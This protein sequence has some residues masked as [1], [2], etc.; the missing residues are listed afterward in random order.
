VAAFL[1][2]GGAMFR[3]NSFILRLFVVLSLLVAL[4]TG[5]IG[6]SIYHRS[7]SVIRDEVLLLNRGTLR[8]VADGLSLILEDGIKLAERISYDSKL[9]EVL[10][11]PGAESSSVGTKEQMKVVSEKIIADYVWSRSN[12]KTLFDAYVIGYNGLTYSTYYSQKY[13]MQS[14]QGDPIYSEIIQR[15]D[16]ITLIDTRSDPEAGGAFRYSFQVAG[17]ISDLITRKPCGFLILNI[18]EKTLYDGYRNIMSEGKHCYVLGQTGTIISSKDKRNIGGIYSAWDHDEMVLPPQGTVLGE[19][20]QEA[21]LIY[22][23]IPGSQW[24]LV[25]EIPLKNAMAAW[26]QIR[27]FILAI[28]LTVIILM[29]ALM[30]WFARQALTP[31]MMIKDKMEQVTGGDL[32]V[33][34]S[35]HRNDEFGQISDSFNAMVERTNSLILAVK[36]EERQ[37]RIVELDFLRAQI[38]PHFI[39]NTLTSIRSFVEMNKNEEAENMLFHFSKLLR[40]TL[41]RSVEFIS[42][43]DELNTIRDYVELQKLRYTEQ[44]DVEYDV[45]DE[46]LGCVITSFILQPIV[47]NAIFYNIGLADPGRIKITG[48]LVQDQIILEVIDNG[49]G[50]NSDQIRDAFSKEHRVNSIGLNNVHERIQL[51]YGPEYGLVI[52]GTPGQ[53]TTVRFIMPA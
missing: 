35:H 6:Y 33:R 7:R 51:N 31:V 47:E 19:K 18:S 29:L 34:I 38:N 25:E 2:K 46:V 48:R 43:E 30:V 32:T 15:G 24:I 12:N 10:Q 3:K 50:M 42:V 14:V 37:K 11:Q 20:G 45:D 5:F 36:E 9:I 39:Y 21:F 4:L 8:Q 26:D 22:E 53:G 27:Y 52:E 1:N 41:T 23:R 40:K 28:T 13:N 49:V 44:F 16:G 17:E